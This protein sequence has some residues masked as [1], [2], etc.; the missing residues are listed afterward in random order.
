MNPDQLV[1]FDTLDL[2]NAN[3]A[4]LVANT[5]SYL[6][7]R[8]RKDN[9]V[10]RIAQSL[11]TSAIL[12]TLRESS[13]TDPQRV[14]DV[15]QRYIYLVAAAMKDP[16]EVWPGLSEINLK[17]LQWG[18][19]LRELIKLENVATGR[20]IVGAPVED[21]NRTSPSVK[22]TTTRTTDVVQRDP[23]H[24]VIIL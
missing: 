18:E 7:E 11:S 15:V 14:Q 21:I 3:E 17:K 23:E 19:E 5:P 12:A 2:G 16:S 20:V 10:A 6:L 9:S 4:V 24:G 1:L 22:A 13:G 8:L